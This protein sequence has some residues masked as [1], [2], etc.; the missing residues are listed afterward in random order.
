MVCTS[1]DSSRN[2]QDVAAELWLHP[3]GEDMRWIATLNLFKKQL[4]KRA[5]IQGETLDRLKEQP[6]KAPRDRGERQIGQI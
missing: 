6:L 5:E 2:R 3:V 1:C 4:K